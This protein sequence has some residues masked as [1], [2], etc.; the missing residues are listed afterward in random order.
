M[1]RPITS[2][3]VSSAWV[4]AASVWLTR[5]SIDDERIAAYP[6]F[7]FGQF[8]LRGEDF[9]AVSDIVRRQPELVIDL[10]SMFG[11]PPNLEFLR[12]D[13]LHPSLAGQKLIAK[14]VVEQLTA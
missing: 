3:A 2:A 6:P 9:E 12:E 8:A 14:T 11:R 13:G 1:T 5:W 7:Q 4:E 10:G